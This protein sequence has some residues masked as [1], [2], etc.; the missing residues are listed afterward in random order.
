MKQSFAAMEHNSG[1]I[2]AQRLESRDIE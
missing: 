2:C 1:A